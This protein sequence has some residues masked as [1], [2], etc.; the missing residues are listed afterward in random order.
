M[1]LPLP[2]VPHGAIILLGPRYLGATSAC[3]YCRYLWSRVVRNREYMWRGGSSLEMRRGGGREMGGGGGGGFFSK[4]KSRGGDGILM[5][6]FFAELDWL[7]GMM[8]G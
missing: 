1:G 6:L 3:I 5:I 8:F 2:V 4:R 7:N